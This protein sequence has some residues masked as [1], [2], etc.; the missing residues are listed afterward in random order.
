MLGPRVFLNNGFR[1]RAA[2]K[3]GVE[4]M[5]FGQRLSQWDMFEAC[6]LAKVNRILR[7]DF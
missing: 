7:K 1:A 6:F 4:R 2:Q 3:S 5:R